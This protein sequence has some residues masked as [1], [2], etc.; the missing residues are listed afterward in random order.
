MRVEIREARA[1][2]VL[3]D[4]LHFGRTAARLHMAQSVLSRLIQRLEEQLVVQLFE[5]STRSVTLTPAGEALVQPA[6]ELVTMSERVSEIVRRAS[7]GETGRVR[8]GFAGASVGHLVAELMTGS[9]RERPGLTVELESS[10]LSRPGLERLQDGSLDLVV[11]R[12]DFLPREIESRVIAQEELLVALPSAHRLARHPQISP[13]QLV[14]EAWVVLPGGSGATLSHRLH[15]LGRHGRFVPR[16]VHT[17]PDS[18]T[19]LLLVEAGEGIAL[20]LSGVRD[21]LPSRGIAF[22]PL[23][24]DLGAVAVR[25]AFRAGTADPAVRAV[26]EV[27]ALVFGGGER[28]NAASAA[29]PASHSSTRSRSASSSGGA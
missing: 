6:R 25:L 3:A 21:S 9:R 18:A 15:L 24:T 14:D 12:W 13:Q 7:A 27:A 17:A 5:R 2:L 29:Q 19:E 20:T 22:R 28:H 4:E 1:F 26:I 11:G 10:Q 23:T 8:L 16:I